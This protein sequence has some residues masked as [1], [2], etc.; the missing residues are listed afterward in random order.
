MYGNILDVYPKMQ[1]SSAAK[2]YYKNC[3]PETYINYLIIKIDAF[4]GQDVND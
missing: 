1:N 3:Q 2:S 4:P